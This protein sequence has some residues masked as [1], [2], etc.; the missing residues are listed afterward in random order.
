MK[1]CD[2]VGQGPLNPEGQIAHPD[3]QELFVT[4]IDPF[5]TKR[6]ASHAGAGRL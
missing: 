2:A 4:E 1:L 3:V 6:A 5:V